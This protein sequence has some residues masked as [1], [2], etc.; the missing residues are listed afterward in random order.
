[1]PPEK[2]IFQLQDLRKF[3]GQREV[4]RGITLSFF[5]DA[6][7]GVIGPNGAGKSSLL[8]I[9]AGVDT[10][11]EGIAKPAAG[12]TIGYLAQEPP[13]DETLDVGGNLELAVAPIRALTDRYNAVAEAMGTVED[14]DELE[15]LSEEMARLDEQIAHKGAWELDSKLEQAATALDLPPM[16][17]DVKRLSGGERRRVALAKLL[18]EQPDMLLLDEPT[19][20]LDAETIE[21]LE[22][23][24][25]NYPGC[26]ILITH[27]RYFLDNVVN[28]MLEIE[29][30]KGTPY[31]GNYSAYLE[32]KAKRLDEKRQTDSKLMRLIKSEREWKAKTPSARTTQSKARLQRL[33]EMENARIE[34]QVESV[35]LR[36]PPGPRLGDK[37]I[38]VVQVT[39]GFGERVL[40]RDLSFS[41]PAGAILGVVGANGMGKST[42][43]RMILG[44]EQPD[45]GHVELGA[46]VQLTYLDQ[47]RMVLDDHKT[48]YDN[49]TEGNDRI[50]FGNT[51][52][53]SRAYVARF[54]FKGEDQQKLLG[55]CSGGMR[56]RVLLA[57]MLKHGSNV[58]LLD[59]P[60]NDLDLDTLR[61]LEEAIQNFPGSAIV[62]SHDRYFL[63]RTVTHILAFEGDGYVNFHHGTYEDYAAWRE[64]W[65][66]RMG[67][68]PESRA[69]RYR[70]LRRG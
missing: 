21:W 64:G 61:V 10:Q 9:F 48:V 39:K 62:V 43:L 27:D 14:A 44:Q 20:H 33:K 5:D 57:R 38:E 29:R 7:I 63:N 30:G 67:F 42:L 4:L 59:E 70:K 45:S 22:E 32:E 35:D 47:S 11:F 17:A 23:H 19:N 34:D 25:K 68:G 31:K 16:D 37:V 8:R 69:G 51:S 52:I 2:I 65:R 56:N 18:M 49:I 13:L 15:R 55:E 36:I 40:I 60:T 66:D 58:I 41:L 12:L 6:K 24:L 26:V 28:W 54:N 50:P 1:M 3:Y 46:S 53:E